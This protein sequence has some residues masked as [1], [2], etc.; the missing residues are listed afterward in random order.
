MKLVLV[1]FFFTV[2]LMSCSNNNQADQH[3][4]DYPGLGQI[5]DA[6]YQ[7]YYDYP[8][9]VND[10]ISF[11]NA[12]KLPENFDTTIEKLKNNRDKIVLNNEKNTL[13]ITLQDSVIYETAHRSPCD[14][15]SYNMGF[16][17]GRVLFFDAMG[18]SITSDEITNQFKSGMKEIKIRY[19][20]VKKEGD[21]NKYVML[22]FVHFKGLT[23]FC[24]ENIQLKDYEYFQEVEKYLNGFSEKYHI[25]RIIFTTP[26]FFK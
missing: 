25:N 11:I 16:Y 1:S 12:C 10:L 8:G 24:N 18:L 3:K 20:K 2:I 7:D 13:I 6:Y 4:Y 15:L 22:N 26:I 23:L 21:T 19:D 17:L 9:T 5:V 14:E